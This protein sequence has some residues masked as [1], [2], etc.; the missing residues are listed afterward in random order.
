MRLD[1]TGIGLSACLTDC[2][3]GASRMRERIAWSAFAIVTMAVLH[4][5]A[6]APIIST[7]T[8]QVTDAEGL[9][10]APN[11]LVVPG[12]S[13]SLSDVV[14]VTENGQNVP[15]M[16]DEDYRVEVLGGTWNAATG[17]IHLIASRQAVPVT[18]YQVSIV[19]SDGTRHRQQ[20]QPDFARIFGPEPGDIQSFDISLE[21]DDHDQAFPMREGTALIPDDTYS[22]RASAMD[23]QGR[24]FATGNPDFPIPLER[25]RIVTAGLDPL[26]DGQ[27]RFRAGRPGDSGEAGY[28]ID[29]RYGEMDGGPAGSLSFAYD[30]AI[31]A[32]PDPTDVNEFELV[33]DL[34]RTESIVPGTVLGL[35]AGVTD[36][37]G[38]TWVWGAEP[39]SL[40]P[41]RQEYPLP[42]SRLTVVAEYAMFDPTSGEIRFEGDGKTMLGD[43]FSVTVRYANVPSLEIRREYDPDF[44]GFVP[45]MQSDTLIFEGEAGDDGDDEDDGDPGPHG[46]ANSRE[47]GSGGDGQP[48]DDG[49]PGL[50]GL[51]GDNG[52]DITIVAQEVY[53][54]DA[55]PRLVL[56]EIWEPGT[57]P[58]YYV[59]SLDGP[60]VT[61]E[62]RGGA[63]GRGGNGGN[64]GSGGNGGDGYNGG[65]GGLGGD[66]GQGGYGG[67]GGDGGDVVLI[68]VSDDLRPAFVLNSLGGAGGEGGLAGSR[69]EGGAPGAAWPED[70]MSSSRQSLPEVG[71][72]GGRGSRA[73]NGQ[74]GQ[75]GRRG[76]IE[77]IVD[78]DQAIQLMTRTPEEI[79]STLLD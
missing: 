1:L 31:E 20:F 23:R 42:T 35:Q 41:S 3:H 46:T 16:L 25:L 40:S 32:G 39:G 79:R 37:R 7:I 69:G 65:D 64:G 75:D 28:R 33:G 2:V 47:L 74:Q 57:Q 52:P 72:E 73:Q 61:I 5:C 51:R 67:L 24:T 66:A 14:A 30:I 29:V 50:N 78:A 43:I 63:G 9:R 44:L 71:S 12:T 55:A 77:R 56:F 70:E 6:T 45:L 38:R 13:L 4:G 59:R 18:G 27:L 19:H 48:G 62:S 10:I 34:A 26:A 76:S 15:L 11:A 17:Q 54:W 58:Q 21:W 53:P 49:L 68:T 8:F 36:F 60:P 22:L